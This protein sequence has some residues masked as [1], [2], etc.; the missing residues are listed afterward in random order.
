MNN[1]VNPSAPYLLSSSGSVRATAYEVA[2]KAVRIGSHTHVTWLDAVSRV[3]V[4]T[5]DHAADRWLDT[6]YLD[7]GIDNHANPCL[8]K[9]PEGKLRLAYGPHGFWEENIWNAARF[10]LRESEQADSVAAWRQTESAGY[11][12]TYACLVTDRQG[13]DH[14]VYRGGPQPQGCLY[15]RR[16]PNDVW[17]RLTKLSAH[18]DRAG[19]TFINASLVVAPGDALFCA[20]MYYT[21]TTGRSAGACILK[22]PDGG[23]TWLGVDDRP[24]QLPLYC[25]CDFA[26]PQEGDVP[27]VLGLACDGAGNPLA[28]TGDLG[29]RGGFYFAAFRNGRWQRTQLDPFMPAGWQL[30]AAMVTVDAQGR[31]LI[32]VTAVAGYSGQGQVPGGAPDS[33]VFLLASGDDGRTFQAVQISETSPDTASW[34]PNISHTGPDYDLSRP[35]L[36]YTHGAPGGGSCFT[37]ERTDVYAVWVD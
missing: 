1:L 11:G 19:Y 7:D 20:F 34:L 35:L 27:Y 32:P 24:V 8:T 21:D 37:G 12:A 31:I 4:R 28:V 15:E 22:S 13:R 3:C 14:L 2:N 17:D 25:H 23:D 5:Y 16:Q 18:A 29:G 30:T 10:K 9:T 26:L 6:V 36:L 33:E